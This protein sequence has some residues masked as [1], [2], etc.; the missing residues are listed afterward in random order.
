MPSNNT[1]EA[2]IP[3]VE[4]ALRFAAN[5]WTFAE[6]TNYIASTIQGD[7]R[8]FYSVLP[9][10][11]FAKH[12][13]R[14]SDHLKLIVLSNADSPPLGILRE[15]EDFYIHTGI[16]RLDYPVHKSWVREQD[17]SGKLCVFL[18]ICNA[19]DSLTCFI[20]ITASR[21]AALY[22]N[23]QLCMLQGFKRGFPECFHEQG[24]I[25]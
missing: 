5:S 25:P 3:L 24:R 19:C 11:G 21:K 20:K 17:N 9:F 18:D 22:E 2:V 7:S 14:F 13:K 23:L 6:Y 15:E 1:Q 12:T 10:L 16:A 4:W 8:C